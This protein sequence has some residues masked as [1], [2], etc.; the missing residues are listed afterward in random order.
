MRRFVLLPSRARRGIDVGAGV[1]DQD[2]RGRLGVILF[3]H[4]DVDFNVLAGARIAQ[5]ILEVNLVAEVVETTEVDE[6]PRGAGGFG[7][8]GVQHQS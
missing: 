6:T 2:Y 1:I 8:T 7:S 5:L 4:S 3:N